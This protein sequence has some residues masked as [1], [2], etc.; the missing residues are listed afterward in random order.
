V[1]TQ[2]FEFISGLVRTRSGIVLTQDKVYLLES[3]LGPLARKEGLGSIDELVQVVRARREER[4]IVQVVDVMTTNE[5]FFFRDK[6]PFDHLKEAV[7]PQLSP[8]RRGSR[9]RIWCAACS[10]GQ[11][12]YSIAM[13]LDQSPMLTGGVPVEIVASDISERCLERAR[14]GLFTQ[15]EV[16]RGLPIQ[17]LMQYFTQQDDQWRISERIRSMVGFRKQNLL[18]PTQGLGKFDVVFCRNVLIYFDNRTKIDILERIASQ[19][20][21][22]GFL[23]LGAA[24]TVIGLTTRFEASQDRRGLYKLSEKAVKAA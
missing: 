15:F 14:Q 16:Q 18:E 13:I 17:M 19:L 9:I 12:P 2:D 3:R 23:M 21:P 1:N 20:N 5:T 7:L 22:G 24:E 11:E 8:Q 10:T 6:T 4:L